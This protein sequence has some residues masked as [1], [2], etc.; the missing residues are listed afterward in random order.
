MRADEP[1]RAADEEGDEAG[2]AQLSVWV[3]VR[4]QGGT[5]S[6]DGEYDN[7]GAPWSTLRLEI[8]DRDAFSADDFIGQVSVPLCPLMDARSH[9]YDLALEDPEGKSAAANGVQGSITFELRY[10]S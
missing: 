9:H 6:A 8:W 5:M 7:P 3:E 1:A 10:L 4:L 2:E